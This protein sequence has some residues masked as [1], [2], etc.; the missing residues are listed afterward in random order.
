MNTIRIGFIGIGNM[1]TALLKGF[2]SSDLCKNNIFNIFDRNPHKLELNTTNRNIFS[3]EKISDLVNDSDIIILAIKPHQ[4]EDILH[5]IKPYINTSKIIVSIVA[6]LSI[7][8][9]NKHLGNNLKIIRTMPNISA[10]INK[11]VTLISPNKFVTENDI[12]SITNLFNSVGITH[13]V[14][15]DSLHDYTALTGSGPAYAFLLIDAMADGAVLLGIPKS[16]AY[17]LAAQT[18]LGASQLL[19]ETNKLPCE[20]KDQVCSPSGTTIEAIRVLEKNCFRSSIIEAMVNCSNKSKAISAE[21]NGKQ[22]TTT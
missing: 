17:T 6:G 18:L 22:D 13:V 15:E 4:L 19:I 1:G 11:G 20:L 14:P 12:N 10:L 21:N 8:F 16:K 7:S 9:I 2:S 3:K 5:Q